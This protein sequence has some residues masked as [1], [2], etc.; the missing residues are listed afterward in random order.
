MGGE[1]LRAPLPGPL[2]R[3]VDVGCGPGVM[4]VLFGSMF[5]DAEVY[6]VDLAEV[7]STEAKPDNVAFIRGDI[8]ELIGPGIKYPGIFQADSFDYVYSR[9]FL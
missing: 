5:P 2:K 8:R 1:Q 9:A 7:S 4:T 3:I 6:G